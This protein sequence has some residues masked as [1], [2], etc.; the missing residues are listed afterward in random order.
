[1]ILSVYVWSY[2]YQQLKQNRETSSENSQCLQ[3]DRNGEDLVEMGIET[4]VN[5]VQDG[6]PEIYCHLH[7]SQGEE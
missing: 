4:N 6:C 5:H 3:I 7:N 1:M 2:L